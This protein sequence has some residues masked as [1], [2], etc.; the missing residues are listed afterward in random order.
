MSS[1]LKVDQIQLADGSTPTAGD[2][3][4]SGSTV[5]VVTGM[6]N[7]SVIASG[8][9]HT[10]FSDTGLAASITPKNASNKVL[11]L[12]SCSGIAAR[13]GGFHQEPD[14]RLIR[15]TT[16]LRVFEQIIY[17][18]GTNFWIPGYNHNT[19]IS[20]QYL[21]TPNT[22]SQVTYKIQMRG[23]TNTSGDMQV[24]MNVRGDGATRTG[25]YGGGS[26]ITLME[27]AG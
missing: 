16:E 11:V 14:L 23:N 4:I 27:I 21:D 17:A 12:I 7:E 25:G 9:A 13:L 10:S 20:G 18:G 3:G 5:Q 8:S 6:F 24:G 15:D 19:S 2:L 26:S 1:I 22:T